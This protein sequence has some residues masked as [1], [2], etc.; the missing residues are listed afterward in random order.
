M[1]PKEREHVYQ[2]F[3][4]CF[5]AL[6]TNELEMI[7]DNSFIIKYDVGD[8]IFKE[9]SLT[10]HLFFVMKGMV[11]IVKTSAHQNTL[12]VR[13]I[14]ENNFVGMLSLLGNRTNDYTA[15]AIQP[16]TMLT[17]HN[18]V[19][20]QLLKSNAEFSNNMLHLLSQYS[21]KIINHL[22][23]INQKL[24]P[25]RVADVL[26]FFKELNN[27]NRF[28][29]PVSRKELAEFA[30]TTKESFIR[31][32]SEFKSDKIIELYDTKTVIILSEEILYKLS[33]LG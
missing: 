23:S 21:L 29:I 7:V 5:P 14:P 8:V 28:V 30:G 32:L 24:L 25:G 11:K 26:L 15:M 19:F 18:D 12:I 3:K 13:I 20:N 31:T 10:S 16:T 9:Q 1:Q 33:R 6:T 2:F 22:I 17:I 4:S 27:S